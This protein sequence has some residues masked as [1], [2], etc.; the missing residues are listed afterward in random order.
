MY[1]KHAPF[2]LNWMLRAFNNQ[3]EDLLTLIPNVR[4]RM[5]RM[6]DNLLLLGR[7]DKIGALLNYAIT[8]YEWCNDHQIALSSQSREFC[9]AQTNFY[10]CKLG[11]LG[12]IEATD[13]SLQKVLTVDKADD[14]GTGHTI[15]VAQWLSQFSNRITTALDPFR[16]LVKPGADFEVLYDPARYAQD[17]RKL[18]EVIQT[19]MVVQLLWA[20]IDPRSC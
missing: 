14:T 16:G 18:K 19:K 13:V 10:G 4:K 3:M 15:G 11:Y 1:W 2:G 6:V 12:T 8:F 17:V 20:R 7:R 9:C 5:E